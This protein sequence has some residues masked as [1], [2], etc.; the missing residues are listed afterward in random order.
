[1]SVSNIYITNV[2]GNHSRIDKKEDALHDERLDDLIKWAVDILLHHVDNILTYGTENGNFDNGIALMKIRGKNYVNVHGD[3]DS[4]TRSG[5]SNLLMMLGFIPY[6][7]TFGHM[8]T[9]AVDE[10]NGIK[11]IRGGSLAGSGDSYTV[12]KRLTGKPSQMVCVCTDK[13]VEAYYTVEL[14]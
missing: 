11:M 10:C 12:E 3:Y 9:C 5:V 6:A 2:S 7:I 1:M 14:N 13:G 4:Y 8:H